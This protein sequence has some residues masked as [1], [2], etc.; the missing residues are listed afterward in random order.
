MN[1]Y[2]FLFILTISIGKI[3]AQSN[4]Q[5]GYIVSNAGDTIHGYIDYRQWDINPFEIKFRPDSLSKQVNYTPLDLKAF[6]V[7]EDHYL[8]GIFEI[9]KSPYLIEDLTTENKAFPDTDT[10]FLTVLVE[11]T[12]NLYYM[13]DSNA[14]EHFFIK[15]N[16]SGI[17]ELIYRRYLVLN[18]DKPGIENKTNIVENNMYKGMLIYYTSELPGLI[19]KINSIRYE[20]GE[21]TKIVDEYN[22]KT[23]CVS[24]YCHINNS[25]TKWI[26][27]IHV[28]SG[29]TYSYYNFSKL[30]SVEE[31][32]IVKADPNQSFVWFSAGIG[33]NLMPPRKLQRFSIYT[34]IL[35]HADK[36][37]Y[38]YQIEEQVQLDHF[39]HY[40][41]YA[42]YMNFSILPR[43]QPK[44]NNI[45][46][47]LNAGLTLSVP[48]SGYYEGYK[49]THFWD[50]VRTE[51]YS[52][53]YPKVGIDA[54]IGLY[55]K[56]FNFDFRYS[57]G[58]KLFF[59][60]SYRIKASD[61]RVKYEF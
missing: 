58:M 6:V 40:D 23:G 3:T 2:L 4:Y 37:I 8:G 15:K 29:L 20:T 34:E 42:H 14:K 41:F 47:Y 10:V 27:S 17:F 1:K 7:S 16:D 18:E 30:L 19:N 60:I 11:G 55:F 56:K 57:L 22:K 26:K 38:N 39:Y 25:R 31:G 24:D 36:Y 33:L 46:P 9:D 32:T 44:F 50:Q 28:I 52:G 53:L 13:K 51:Y 45:R 49:E 61:R 21:L 59:M 43:Y 5:K 35:Y 12:L 48:V 54:G